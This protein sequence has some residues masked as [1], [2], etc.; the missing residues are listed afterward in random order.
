MKRDD[1]TM[2][3]I[4]GVALLLLAGRKSAMSIPWGTGWVW[5]V[6]PIRFS[7]GESY[8]PVIS[9]PFRSGPHYGVDVMFRRKTPSDRATV[10]PPGSVNGSTMFFAP[11]GT[12]IVAAKDAR[13]WSTG[14]TARGHHVVL[15]HGKPF[16]TFYQHLDRLDIEPH[17]NGKPTSGGS[18][19]IVKA[20]DYIG[21]M[22]GDPSAPPHLRHLHFAVWYN[23]SGD[24]ASV[25]PGPVI[26]T[27]GVVA[28]WSVP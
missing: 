22:G 17:A 21:T 7:D 24:K 23:G 18:P 5:P 28:P 13:V 19:T 27:W 8:P 11:P 10:Y 6:A 2:L 14:K 1:E 12:P 4:G 25:D 20:G 16:A 26:S 3:V 15:D 9:N